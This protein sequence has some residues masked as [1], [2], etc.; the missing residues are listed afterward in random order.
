[1]VGILLIGIAL[2]LGSVA[3]PVISVLLL[4]AGIALLRSP[5]ASI[6]PDRNATNGYP[7]PPNSSMIDDGHGH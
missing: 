4:V 5:D 2:I 7:Y 6:V 3:P 1:M